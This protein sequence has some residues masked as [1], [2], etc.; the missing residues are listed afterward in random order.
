MYCTIL[1]VFSH[2]KYIT[3]VVVNWNSN[4]ISYGV[5]NQPKLQLHS[6][7][8]VI[9]VAFYN[10]RNIQAPAS[11]WRSPKEG[12]KKEI[13]ETSYEFIS[14]FRPKFLRTVFNENIEMKNIKHILKKSLRIACFALFDS[15]LWVHLD[16]IIY[17]KYILYEPLLN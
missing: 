4:E 10:D 12:S 6:E 16:G 7:G 17:D 5:L 14:R 2:I 15:I 8:N 9:Y 1:K 13:S 3:H 11:R